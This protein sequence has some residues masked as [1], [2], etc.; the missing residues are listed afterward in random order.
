MKII[1]PRIDIAEYR[2]ALEAGTIDSEGAVIKPVLALKILDQISAE[3]FLK[4]AQ[5]V[6]ESDELSYGYD[7]LK[8]GHET[9]YSNNREMTLALVKKVIAVRH[10]KAKGESLA[11]SVS[12]MFDENAF[13]KVTS[14]HVKKILDGYIPKQDDDEGLTDAY[15]VVSYQITAHCIMETCY[16]F[17]Q[18]NKSKDAA[19]NKTNENVTT[20]TDNNTESKAMNEFEPMSDTQIVTFEDVAT[21]IN[22]GVTVSRID[23]KEVT[24][25]NSYGTGGQQVKMVQTNTQLILDYKAGYHIDANLIGNIIL[26]SETTDNTVFTELPALIEA[27]KQ[28]SFKFDE[29][30]SYLGL[31][32][33][34]AIW[35]G[36]SD[37][38]LK[39]KAL[40]EIDSIKED[41][42][43]DDSVF[44]QSLH[45]ELVGLLNSKELEG[46]SDVLEKAQ[47]DAINFLQTHL[48]EKLAADAA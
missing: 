35:V 18:Y 34:E 2:A 17:N 44:K 27:V 30:G 7:L 14:D 21:G 22:K 26:N 45:G 9:F 39:S 3:S 29:F 13:P 46:L 11:Q 42:G 16:S 24:V 19:I 36:T 8:D 31:S 10:P 20:N 40:S 47:Q 12:S 33:D 32:I 15:H 43:I 6:S 48:Q 5:E 1:A 41:C 25:C 28:G 4:A 38:S 23:T 37:G